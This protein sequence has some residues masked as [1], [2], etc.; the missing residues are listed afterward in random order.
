M[1]MNHQYIRPL[2]CRS[3]PCTLPW[4]WIPM[5][6]GRD[7]GGREQD[8]MVMF[9]RRSNCCLDASCVATRVNTYFVS[10]VELLSGSNLDHHLDVSRIVS[11]EFAFF[12]G[13][14]ASIVGR[15]QQGPG[16]SDRPTAVGITYRIKHQLPVT[17]GLSRLDVA[18][19]PNLKLARLQ[20]DCPFIISITE[21]MLKGLQNRYLIWPRSSPGP[22]EPGPNL[23][24]THRFRR[25]NIWLLPADEV[26]PSNSMAGQT[27]SD[28]RWQ[29]L[30]AEKFGTMQYLKEAY[31]DGCISA[32]NEAWM[33]IRPCFDEAD[34]DI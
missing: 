33:D 15:S 20:H 12:Y 6:L 13:A 30:G 1:V 32:Q 26:Q 24:R 18:G 9:F 19:I 31:Q 23:N 7:T 11:L 16:Q 14:N 17:S 28:P 4:M 29:N 5:V 2:F 27:D 21:M 25:Q 8:L 10:V 3:I 34:W 22:H